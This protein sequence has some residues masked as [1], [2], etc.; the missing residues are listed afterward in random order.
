[1]TISIVQT[2]Y[3]TFDELTLENGEALGP[4]TMGY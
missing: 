3:F 2:K 4:I 1:M